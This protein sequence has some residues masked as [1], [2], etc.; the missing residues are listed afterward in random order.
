MH[1]Y[2]N[3]TS[4]DVTLYQIFEEVQAGMF[5]KFSSYSNMHLFALYAGTLG[6]LHGSLNVTF[7]PFTPF[8]YTHILG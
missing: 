6:F 2:Y 5:M 3:S 7:T 8:H 1:K 4:K